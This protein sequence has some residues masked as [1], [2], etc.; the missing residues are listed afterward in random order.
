MKA[1]TIILFTLGSIWFVFLIFQSMNLH[2]IEE[3]GK[4][5]GN[6]LYPVIVIGIGYWTMK[7][8]EEYQSGDEKS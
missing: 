6:A 5:V 7:K 8:D 4:M 3:S 2:S 1:T